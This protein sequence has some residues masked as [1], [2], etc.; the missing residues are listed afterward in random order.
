MSFL[1]VNDLNILSF[2]VLYSNNDFFPLGKKGTHL[3]IGEKTNKKNQYQKSLCTYIQ[4]K[5][6]KYLAEIKVTKYQVKG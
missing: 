4:Y 2:F 3:G 1:L 5:T 6:S